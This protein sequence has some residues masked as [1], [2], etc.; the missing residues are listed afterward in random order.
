MYR[1]P[2]NVEWEYAARAGTQMIFSF[3]DDEAKLINYGWFE[4]NS[5]RQTHAV[6]LKLSN[7]WGL[8]DVYGNVGEFVLEDVNQDATRI[9]EDGSWNC[10][11]VKRFFITRG[12][13]WD[14]STGSYL[15]SS[16]Q[17]DYG[18]GLGFRCHSTGF[19]LVR[20]DSQ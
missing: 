5:G 11:G 1:L 13:A 4:K 6:G 20:T 9:A 8:Y 19:R 7:L 10:S 14:Q 17:E 12:G 18:S 3:G 16:G 15:S 2:K